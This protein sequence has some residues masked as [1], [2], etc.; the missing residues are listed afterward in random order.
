MSPVFQH[1][2]QSIFQRMSNNNHAYFGGSHHVLKGTMLI[3]HVM[4]GC[5]IKLG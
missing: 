5:Q 1:V 3:S 2:F 4:D